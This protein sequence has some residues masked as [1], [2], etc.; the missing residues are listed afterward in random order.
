MTCSNKS[1]LSWSGY[2]KELK[3]CSNKSG[4]S[5]IRVWRSAHDLLKQI[6][7]VVDQGIAQSSRIAPTNPDCSGS[8]YGA[9]LKTFFNKSGLS[10]IRVW[11]SAQD[12]LQEIWIIVD[13]GYDAEFKTCSN[14]SGLSRIRVWRRAHDLLKQIRIV[15]DQGMAQSSRFSQTNPD[16]VDQGMV[17]SSRLAPTN[18]DCRGSGYGAE[19][20]TC[21]NKS[22]LSWTWAWL[23]AEFKTSS[24]KVSRR[25]DFAISKTNTT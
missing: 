5:W 13:Q 25:P 16:R 11:R 22:G 21:S 14:K 10:W 23:G 2:D 24:D 19:L 18:P 17:Q 1:E 8:G 20:R 9:E 3:T 7:I 15:V 12:L 4:F 6:R